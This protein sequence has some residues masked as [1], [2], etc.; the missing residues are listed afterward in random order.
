MDAGLHG[1]L[2]HIYYAYMYTYI[3]IYTYIYTY[4]YEY[5]YTYMHNTYVCITMNA[6]VHG[7]ANQRPDGNHEVPE[8]P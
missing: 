6:G 3:Y 4:I 2:D 8:R 1:H 7:H 5:L